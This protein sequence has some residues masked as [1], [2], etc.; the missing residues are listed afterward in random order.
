MLCSLKASKSYKKIM[1]EVNKLS[2]FSTI[3]RPLSISL[4][5]IADSHKPF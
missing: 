3:Y 4:S 2:M 1:I 5:N